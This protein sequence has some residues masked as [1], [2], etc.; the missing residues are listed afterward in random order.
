VDPTRKLALFLR[1]ID[2]EYQE[3]QEADFLARAHLH[4]CSPVVFDA[5]N[6]PLRQRRQID[7]V[8][9]TQDHYAA[10]LTQPVQESTLESAAAEA[11]RR[12]IAWV[13]LNRCTDYVR[14]LRMTQ[15]KA[16][17]FCVAPDQ[18]QIGHIQGQQFLILLRKGGTLFYLTGPPATASARQ[19][20]ASVEIALAGAAIKMIPAA[21]DWT[22]ESGFDATRLWL[23]SDPPRDCAH[24]VVG[25][26]NDAMAV[27]A[28]RAVLEEAKF[29]GRPELETVRITGCDGL[30]N[31]GQRWVASGTLTATVVMP[32]TAGVAVDHLASGWATGRPPTNDVILE[33]ASFPDL[34]VLSR[35]TP[36]SSRPPRSNPRRL[37]IAPSLEHVG[38]KVIAPR[39]PR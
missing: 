15:P 7:D 39:K 12:G 9:R 17:V 21:G 29:R 35:T 5:G 4:R 36:I 2:N 22:T 6:D 16:P 14:E 1:A 30:P 20:L 25:A 8:L 28:R 19:R 23:R 11:I 27:G 13:A 26:Q 10:L 38:P 18:H 33:V 3:L 31:G 37:R 32:T 34:D 24:L